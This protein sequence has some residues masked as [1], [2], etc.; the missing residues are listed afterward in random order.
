MNPGPSS[1]GAR[2]GARPGASTVTTQ[3]QLILLTLLYFNNDFLEGDKGGKKTP[4]KKEKGEKSSKKSAK[5]ETQ[6]S[7]S[8]D[9][10]E[11]DFIPVEKK[12]EIGNDTSAPYTQ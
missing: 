11:E 10:N 9:I 6:D 2:P 3:L 7:E 4:E 1:P 5:K 8:L 12:A